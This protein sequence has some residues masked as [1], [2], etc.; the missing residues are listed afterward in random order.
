MSSIIHLSVTSVPFSIDGV[1]GIDLLVSTTDAQGR[2]ITGLKAENFTIRWLSVATEQA[3]KSLSVTEFTAASGLPVMPGVYA[4][5]VR[6]VSSIWAVPK[7][8][9]PTFFIAVQNKGCQGQLLYSPPIEL[10][11]L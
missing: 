9:Y 2:A 4:V 6:S 3:L 11:P 8:V 7:A 1:A 5:N 10:L